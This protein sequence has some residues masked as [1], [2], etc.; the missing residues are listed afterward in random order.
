MRRYVKIK[1]SASGVK[2]PLSRFHR[3]IP[4]GESGARVV[5]VTNVINA[6]LSH[7]GALSAL[8]AMSV[9]SATSAVGTLF[10]AQE[11]LSVPL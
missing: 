5:P 6:L 7:A 8:S 9:M 11:G 1:Q 2:F 3:D 10:E 4:K